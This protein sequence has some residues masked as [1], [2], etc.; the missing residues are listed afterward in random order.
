MDVHDSKQK[1]KKAIEKLKKDPKISNNNKQLILNFIDYILAD[2]L[3]QARALKYIY[4]LKQISKILNKDFD[5]ITKKDVILFFKHINTNNDFQEW[6]KHDY[7]VLT[8][9]FYQWVKNEITVKS[10]EI[11]LA[12]EEICNKEIKRAKS[13]EKLPEHLLTS[14]EILKIADQTL[15]SRDRAFIL[16]LYD[17]A[18]RIGEILPVKI[19]DIEFDQYGCKINVTGKTGFRP[20]RLCAS[21]QAISN[22]LTNHPDRNNPMAFLFCGLGKKNYKKMLSYESARKIIFEAAKRAGV[23]K[24]VNLHIFR[25]S[26]ATQLVLEGM[27]EPVLCDFGGWK[28]G[29][30]EIRT[31]VKLSGKNVEDEILRINGLVKEEIVDGFKTIICPRC[32][33]K[34]SPGSKFC[35]NCS[36]GMDVKTVMNFEKTKDDISS[37]IVNLIEDKDQALKILDTLAQ[38]LKKQ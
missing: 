4:T 12:I 32:N 24:R 6:T 35:N 23:K 26:R 11:R 36:L 33:S 9:R 13:R 29:S 21:S 8:R 25:A 14:D 27:S 7:K 30:S 5:N 20:I 19:K 16:S 34:N 18:C 38:M 28:I 15:N 17:S 31:Y 37:S 2:G 1:L 3:S 22:W 10:N